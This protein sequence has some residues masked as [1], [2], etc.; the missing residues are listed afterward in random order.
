MIC[1]LSRAASTS[2]SV[3][4]FLSKNLSKPSYCGFYSQIDQMHD[5]LSGKSIV[6]GHTKCRIPLYRVGLNSY[7]LEIVNTLSMYFNIGSLCRH[8]LSRIL[9]LTMTFSTKTLI[10]LYR[11]VEDLP[12]DAV[13]S[14]R[15]IFCSLI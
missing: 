14:P 13:N 4:V 9:A 8:I 11:D 5:I 6:N 1:W 7:L 3:V 2:L 15:H 12:R 10:G